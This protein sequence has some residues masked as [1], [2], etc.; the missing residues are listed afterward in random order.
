MII[1]ITILCVMKCVCSIAGSE[2]NLVKGLEPIIIKDH[3]TSNSSRDKLFFGFN[4]FSQW[5]AAV[6]THTAKEETAKCKAAL[7]SKSWFGEGLV[8][9]GDMAKKSHL[10][11]AKNRGCQLTGWQG[12]GQSDRCPLHTVVWLGSYGDDRCGP[13]LGL[14]YATFWQDGPLKLLVYNG[15]VG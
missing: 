12:G 10:V 3:F 15:S 7:V 1:Y 4:F 6:N 2:C 11:K 13:M 9:C 14:V 5:V 8:T